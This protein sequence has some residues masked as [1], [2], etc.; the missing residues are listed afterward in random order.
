MKVGTFCSQLLW[1]CGK[2]ENNFGETALK[3]KL[4][5]GI[6]RWIHICGIVTSFNKSEKLVWARSGFVL[7]YN[8]IV[9]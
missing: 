2:P 1:Y 7:R 4:N 6:L 9:Y 8:A 3:L 5:A